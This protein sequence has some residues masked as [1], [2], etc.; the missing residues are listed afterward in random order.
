M[1]A[2]EKP[3]KNKN[4]RN[5]LFARTDHSS[6]SSH[7]VGKQ[8]PLL[9]LPTPVDLPRPSGGVYPFRHYPGLTSSSVGPIDLGFTT[10]QINRCL[11]FPKRWLHLIKGR[12]MPVGVTEEPSSAPSAISK[13]SSH[14]GFRYSSRS[15][16]QSTTPPPPPLPIED[17][18]PP[19]ELIP[20]Q[21]S[22]PGTAGDKTFTDYDAEP[23]TRI[24]IALSDGEVG[25]ELSLLQDLAG[26]AEEI[27]TTGLPP[28]VDVALKPRIR[29]IVHLD[30]GFECGEDEDEE[31]KVA[32]KSQEVEADSTPQQKHAGVTEEPT[33]LTPSVSFPLN[34]RERKHFLAPS[35][36]KARMNGRALAIS[37]TTIVTL[38]PKPSL[39]GL[40][41]PH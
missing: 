19:A 38:P 31:E 9:S 32:D 39:D 26:R 24:S 33:S 17:E 4:K 14:Q 29:K 22:P 34:L 10:A 36:T 15:K 40:T 1:G 21:A 12:L 11:N 37:T 13:R 23:I 7:H 2:K 16:S 35:T 25:I 20:D 27:A 5:P 30:G 41:L 18:T 3:N 8:G 6:N 28:I